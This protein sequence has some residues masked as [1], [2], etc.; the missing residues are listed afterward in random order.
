VERLQP[1]WDAVVAAWAAFGTEMHARDWIDLAIA[2]GTV[3][4][5][6]ATF[7]LAASARQ[8]ARDSSAALEAFRVQA[9]ATESLAKANERHADLAGSMLEEQREQFMRQM[10]ARV[11]WRGTPDGTVDVVEDPP[12]WQAHSGT[13]LRFQ[14]A[15]ANLSAGAVF[16]DHVE[17]GTAVIDTVIQDQELAGHGET[18]ITVFID[19]PEGELVSMIG[20]P[21]KLHYQSIASGAAAI[22]EGGI[23]ISG[24]VQASQLDDWGQGATHTFD[25]MAFISPAGKA[26]PKAT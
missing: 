13:V 5:A 7:R 2:L 17:H 24:T 4:L 22:A 1:L 18:T 8:S 21:L 23:H 20:E 11:V 3:A 14:A 10:A 15:V 25:G 6:F 26:P 16:L 19:A 9:R 12:V